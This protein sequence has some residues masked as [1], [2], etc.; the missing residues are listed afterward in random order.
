MSCSPFDLKDYFFGELSP[1]DRRTVDQHLSACADC[2]EELESLDL[3]RSALMMIPDEE[4]PRRI[5]FVSDKVFEPKWWQIRSWSQIWNSAARL[6]FVSSALLAGSI[7]AHGV[8]M[9]PAPSV[10]ANAPVPAQVMVQPAAT[11]SKDME[12]EVAKRVKAEL[13]KVI[14]ESEERQSAKLNQVVAMQ[15]KQEFNTRADMVSLGENFMVLQKQM[16]MMSRNNNVAALE[17]GAR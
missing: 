9:R 16:R 5:A 8:L 6:G 15:K 14:L 7:L 1:G 13:Q 12:V 4:P 2:R 3:T 17:G 10:V 11:N